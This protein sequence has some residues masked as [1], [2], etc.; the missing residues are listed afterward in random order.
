M[1]QF[2]LGDLV[3]EQAGVEEGVQKLSQGNV[4]HAD[5]V[6]QAVTLGPLGLFV[7]PAGVPVDRMDDPAAVVAVLGVGP[8]EAGMCAAEDHPPTGPQHP[9][10]FGHDRT[11]IVHI[12]G[13]PSCNSRC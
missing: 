2:G 13:Q 1:T 11:E 6:A 7:M 9:G 12:G 4:A 3:D 8:D 5:P 10:G